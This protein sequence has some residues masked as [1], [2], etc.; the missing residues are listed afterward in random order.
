MAK[1]TQL[2]A[3]QKKALGG[4]IEEAEQA[5]ADLVKKGTARAAAA[6]AEISAYRGQWHEVLGHVE[7]SVAALDQFETFDVQIDQITLCSLA[8]RQTESWDRAAKT[9]EIGR[10]SLG[11][12]GD[13][14]L[15]KI[16]AR[17]AAFAAS[18][19]SEDFR[20]PQGVQLGGAVR[21]AEAVVKVEGSKKKFS[22]PQ[23]RAD[24]MIGL[25]RVYEY[26]EGAVQMFEKDNTLPGIF[27][28]V[29]FLAAALA[30]AGRSDD[31]WAV[32][33]GGISDWWPVEETQ[34]APVV[35]LTDASLAPI[36]TA[37]RC[38]EILDTPRGS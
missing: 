25:A 34:I 33:R 13:P 28:N 23:T 18:H 4:D 22:D 10:R 3:A 36:M 30:K 12:K 2:E 5:F 6:L 27:D 11:K 20:L 38:A 7:T 14:D 15:L 26:H 16:L 9:A 8:A 31:A 21:F 32:I 29:V 35:L 24:H 17:L 37:V 19:G 1:L